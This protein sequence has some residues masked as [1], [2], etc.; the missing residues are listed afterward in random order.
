MKREYTKLTHQIFDEDMNP[1][2]EV[3][4]VILTS[5]IAD[6]GKIFYCKTTGFVGGTRIDVGTEDSEDNYVEI[7]IPSQA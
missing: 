4:E 6:E 3:E 2:G 1:V 5:L 7:D